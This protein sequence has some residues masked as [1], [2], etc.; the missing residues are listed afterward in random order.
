MLQILLAQG[1]L[2]THWYS[3][4]RHGLTLNV[5]DCIEIPAPSHGDLLNYILWTE[6]LSPW[7]AGHPVQGH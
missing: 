1:K 2:F 4:P 5:P 7:V 3:H 6:R